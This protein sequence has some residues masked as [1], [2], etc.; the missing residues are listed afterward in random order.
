MER[1][2]FKPSPMKKD[3]VNANST[4]GKVIAVTSGKG[5]VGKSTVTALLARKLLKQGYKVG[6]MDA[7][8]TGPSIPKIFGG[9]AQLCG[10]EFGME[11]YVSS[12]GIKIISMNFLLEHEEDPVIWRGPLIAQVV[13]QFW[14]EVHWGE[15]DYLLIDMPPGT[16][17]VALTIYQSLP[18]DGVVIVTSP[19]SLVEMIV[20]KSCKMAVDMNI[21]VLGMVENY[22]CYKCPDCGKIAYI[23]GESRIDAIAGELKIPVLAKLPIMPELAKAEDEGRPYEAEV[24]IDIS[25]ITSL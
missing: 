22:S 13:K 25:T 18:V 11:P 7:D 19:Q 15:I 9:K 14:T 5:G 17:D 21:P 20:S 4:V 6:I 16:G 2:P 3:K 8:I 24:D 12:E 10:G 23:F 1:E